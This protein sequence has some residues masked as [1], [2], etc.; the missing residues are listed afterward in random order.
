M[1]DRMAKCHIAENAGWS[2][3]LVLVSFKYLSDLAR[4]RQVIR[5]RLPID[6]ESPVQVTTGIKLISSK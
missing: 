6:K 2:W 5:I 1:N 3:K 4:Q